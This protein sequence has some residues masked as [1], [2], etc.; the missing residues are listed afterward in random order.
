MNKFNGKLEMPIAYNFLSCF[1]LNLPFVLAVP[2]GSIWNSETTRERKTILR[3]MILFSGK[4]KR[5]S[6]IIK[7]PQKFHIFKFLSPYIIVRNK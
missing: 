7:T 1:F 4:Y 6:N 2:L 3:K 5:K